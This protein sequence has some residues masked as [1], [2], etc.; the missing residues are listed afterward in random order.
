MISVTHPG[1]VRI[2]TIVSRTDKSEVNRLADICLE[3]DSS[4]F[5]P[6][7]DILRQRKIELKQ[8]LFMVTII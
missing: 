7:D 1:E 3:F 5:S 8:S 6:K 2:T 4:T